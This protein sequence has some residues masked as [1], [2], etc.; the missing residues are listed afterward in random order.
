MGY[1]L[2][3][4]LCILHL[5][6]VSILALLSYLLKSS[7]V[8]Q[9]LKAWRSSRALLS[10]ICSYLESIFCVTN[11]DFCLTE[12]F[13]LWKQQVECMDRKQRIGDNWCDKR[14]NPLQKVISRSMSRK[15]R[16]D[17]WIISLYIWGKKK[18]TRAYHM[19]KM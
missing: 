9:L 4:A 15:R 13:D 14:E 7:H 2:S 6:Y 1:S 3:F 10:T 8:Y 18:E 17:G 11:F 16:G 19:N 12:N 5:L